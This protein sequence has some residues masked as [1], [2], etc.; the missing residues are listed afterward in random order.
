[1]LDGRLP[2]SPHEV[3]LGS[4]TL[5]AL[6]LHIGDH[7]RVRGRN[8][9]IRYRVVGRVVVPSL[10]D[11][12]AIADGAVFTG[13][14]LHRIPNSDAD[15][16]FAVVVRF[17]PG[18]DQRAAANRIERMP[19][20]GGFGHAGV[21]RTGVPLEVRRLDQVDW[22]PAALAVFLALL[23]TL[24]VGHLLVTSLRRRRR[25]FAVLKTLGCGRRQILTMVAWQATTVALFAIVVGVVLGVAA[26]SALWRAAAT[27][28]G[29]LQRVDVPVIALAAVAAAS[30]VLA[31]AIAL[32]PGRAA[33]TTR[34]AATL[35][36]E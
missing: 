18:V 29:V 27:S 25:D 34:V 36:S 2:R 13:P 12:Q 30:L 15:V 9:P 35:R 28:V 24:A 1:V 6:D 8:E 10:T 5:H 14:G 17:R 20:I 31:N 33:A 32:L 3:A 19:G 16:N 22:M 7:T 11:P 23:G 21:E 4:E 26:G